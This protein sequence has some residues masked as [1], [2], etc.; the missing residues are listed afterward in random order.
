[1]AIWPV[2]SGPPAGAARPGEKCLAHSRGMA[3]GEHLN[4]L[5]ANPVATM[6]RLRF[7]SLLP[8]TGRGGFPH[9]FTKEVECFTLGLVKDGGIRDMNAIM[10][11]GFMVFAGGRT[12]AAR[13]RSLQR[14][15]AFF[16]VNLE[17][18]RCFPEIFRLEV[19]HKAEIGADEQLPGAVAIPVD[20]TGMSG[21]VPELEWL[22]GRIEEQH[23][24]TLPIAAGSPSVSGEPSPRLAASIGRGKSRFGGALRSSYGFVISTEGWRA[25]PAQDYSDYRKAN[26]SCNADRLPSKPP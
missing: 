17:G 16:A 8:S 18:R 26:R 2:A 23:F 11:Y 5:S 7:P 13:A 19:P 6:K 24:R 20:H 4:S 21:V 14:A 12:P 1:M 3:I 15:I 22:P 10:G 9:C 25:L